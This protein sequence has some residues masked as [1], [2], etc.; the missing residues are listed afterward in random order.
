[1]TDIRINDVPDEYKSRWEKMKADLGPEVTHREALKHVLDVY[2]E[3]PEQ[4]VGD[5]SDV[6]FR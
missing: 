2:E 6:E 3:N 5:D 1:M 4:I